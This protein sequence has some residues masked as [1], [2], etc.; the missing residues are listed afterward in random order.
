MHV[1]VFSAAGS[2][3]LPPLAFFFGGGHVWGGAKDRHVLPLTTD[4]QH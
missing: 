2:R 4:A 3:G 1:R